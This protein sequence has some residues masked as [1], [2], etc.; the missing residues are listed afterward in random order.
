ML[1]R[2]DWPWLNLSPYQ[3]DS[4]SLS[5]VSSYCDVDGGGLGYQE[6]SLCILSPDCELYICDGDDD[7]ST[8]WWVCMLIGLFRMLVPVE[9]ETSVC[10]CLVLSCLWTGLWPQYFKKQYLVAAW[11]NKIS[12]LILSFIYAPQSRQRVAGL[13]HNSGPFWLA[14]RSAN[15][16]YLSCMWFVVLYII[17]YSGQL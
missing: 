14:W 4:D 8:D 5:V 10:C 17:F 1:W 15:V 16:F 7:D 12:V 11:V 6:N 13:F 2:C 9:L 3:E